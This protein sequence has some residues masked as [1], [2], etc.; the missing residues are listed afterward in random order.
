MKFYNDRG[1]QKVRRYTREEMQ[2]YFGP[3]GRF[4]KTG[5]IYFHTKIKK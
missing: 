4:N 1:G 5:V 3:G 2:K